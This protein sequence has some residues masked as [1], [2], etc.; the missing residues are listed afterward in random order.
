MAGKD[1]TMN[2]LKPAGMIQEGNLKPA[3]ADLKQG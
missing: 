3:E 2:E 1:E